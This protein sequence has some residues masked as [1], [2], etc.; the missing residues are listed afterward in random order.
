MKFTIHIRYSDGSNPFLSLGGWS[1]ARVV[2]EAYFQIQKNRNNIAY[3]D[4]YPYHEIKCP[5]ITWRKS[6]N[7][8]LIYSDV[9]TS[10]GYIN[11]GSALNKLERMVVHEP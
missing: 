4:I 3:I 8:W 1:K 11:L 9:Y 6:T 2:N 10:N 5:M 7:R